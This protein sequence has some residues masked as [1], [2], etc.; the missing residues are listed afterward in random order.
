MLH[1]TYR[2][3][4]TGVG[5]VIGI[6]ALSAC[7]TDTKP[8][9]EQKPTHP[10]QGTLLVDGKPIAG[11]LVI[12]HPQ[13]AADPQMVRSYGRT[14]KDGRFTLSTYKPGDGA[15]AGKYIVTA[16]IQDPDNEANALPAHVGVPATSKLWAVV[17]EGAN[18]LPV[19]RISGR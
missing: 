16:L 17:Q 3:T 10:V 15:P 19:F 11:V 1:G 9:V 7:S 18:D 5:A 2:H 13:G 8:A 6:V 4:L 12:F 14:E